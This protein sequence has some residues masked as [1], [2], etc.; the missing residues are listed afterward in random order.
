M[1]SDASDFSG[2]QVFTGLRFTYGAGGALALTYRG[3]S[4][5]IN[6]GLTTTTFSSATVYTVEI[7]GNNKTS[8]TINY[9][10]GANARSVAVQKFDLYINGALIGDDLA[11]ALLPAGTNITSNTFIGVSSTANAANVFVDDVSVYN[12]VPSALGPVIT[13]GGPLTRQQGTAASNATIATVSDTS[14]G[15]LT[16]TATT[17]PVGIT[18][19]TIVNSSGTVT[20]DVAADCTAATG[21]NTVVL[22]LT[23]GTTGLT[24]TANLTVNVDPNTPPVLTYNSANVT[25][26]TTGT[27][28][29]ATGPS[30]NGSVASIVLQ[31]VTP[32][33]T[34]GTLTVNNTTGVVTVPNNIP[35][36]TYTVT[37]RATDNC[38]GA[39]GTTDATFTLT[40]QA[41]APILG[42]Y[43]ATTLGL[44]AST[45]VTPSAAPQNTTSLSVATNTDFKGTFAADP[46]TG[47]VRVTNAHPAGTYTVTVTAFNGSV[48]AQQT[49][50]LMV[51]NGTACTASIRFTNAA[52]VSVGSGPKAMSI[53]DFNGDGNQDLAVANGD[54]ST[55]SI[56][57]GD[58]T[59]SFSGTSNVS[60]GANPT[61]VAIGDFNRDGNQDFAAACN[62]AGAVSIRLGNGSGGFS[63][64]T[65]VSVGANT[66]SVAIGD[67]NGD[68]KQDF[69][70]S[71]AGSNTVSIRLGDGLG[72]FSGTTNVSVG[73]NPSSVAIGDFNEDGKQDFAVA[74]DGPDTVAIR[75]GDGLGGFSGTTSLSVGLNPNAV[76]IGDFNGDGHQDLAVAN[77]SS[78]SVS[79]RLGDGTGGFSGSAL[80]DF[81]A[82]G[83]ESVA[84]GDFN[85]DGK[86][87]FATSGRGFGVVTIRLG[88]GLGGFG[89]R[90]FFNV[91][92]SSIFVAIGDFNGDG[93]QDF[94][95]T[96]QDSSNL[97][98]RLG[99][100]DLPPSITPVASMLTAGQTVSATQ[101]ATAADAVDAANTL[102]LAISSDGTTFGNSATL[103]GVTVT[104]TDSNAGATGTNP[105]ALGN[106]LANVAAACA[107]TNATF[108]LRVTD[109]SGN[110]DT[111]D[112]SVTVNA[113]NLGITLGASPTVLQGTTSANLPYT[114]TTGSPNQ[115]SIDYDTT[116]NTAGFVDVSNATLTAS[117][118]VLVIPGAAAAATYNA[119]LTVRDSATGCISS[120]VSF[121]VTV[122]ACPTTFTVEDTIDSPDDN[123][124]DGV[125]GDTDSICT[126]RAAIMEANALAA[127][128]CGSLTIN[129]SVTGTINVGTELPWVEHPNL[130]IQGPGA[131]LL[132]VTRNAAAAFTIFI[133]TGDVVT[134]ND[135]TIS[136]GDAG[137]LFPVGGGLYNGG[138][139][140]TINRCHITGNTANRGG[141]VF[142]EAGDT[143]INDSTI[144]NNSAASEGGGVYNFASEGDSSITLTNCTISGNSVTGSGGPATA[145]GV[146]IYAED[147][148]NATVNLVNCT[149]TNNTAASSANAGGIFSGVEDGDS[150]ANINLINTIL[151]GNG[152][153][154]ALTANGGLITS[155]GNNLDGDGT[156]GFTNGVNGDI[157]GTVGT[158]INPLL[159]VLG[160][161]GG[162][163][164]THALLP[165]SPAIN[166]GTSTGAPAADQRGIARPQLT[167][168][169]I[170]AFESQGFTLA[171]A[172][173]NNQSAVVNS[174][175]SLPLS[176]T[177][178]ANDA[179]VPVDGGIV[180]FTPPG[181]GASATIASNPATIGGGTATSGTVTA[182]SVTG[183]YS[184][185]ANASGATAP[186][187]FSL[188]NTCQTITVNA[189]GINT[190]TVGVAFSQMF[191]QTGGIG[192][193]TFSTAS[194]LP[195]GITLAADGTLAGTPTQGGAFPLVVVATDSNGCTGSVNYTLTINA[196]P[197]INAVA[198]TRIEGS[199]SSSSTIAN[200]SDT[201]T[202][203]GSLTV[204]VNSAASATV[205]GVT[206]SNLI[207]TGGTISADV[208]AACGATTANFTL[209]VT[210]GGGATNTAMLTVTVDANTPPVLTYSNASVLTG[211]SQNISP[212]T[213]PSDNGSVTTIAVQDM[214][215]YTGGIS[216]NNLTGVISISAAAPSG[217]HT[218]TIRA[219]DQCGAFTDA[220]FTLTVGCVNTLTVNNLGEGAD[221]APGDGV[222]ETANGNGICTLRAA[223]QEANALPGCSP[224]TINFSVTGTITL[225][226]GQLLVTHPNLTVNGPGASQL[227]VSGNNAS[228]IFEI[229]IAATA[230][231]S[232]VTIT[233][234]NGIGATNSGDGG[235]IYSKGK[236]TLTGCV[237]TGNTTTGVTIHEGG[238]INN[239]GTQLLTLT[240]CTISNNTANF[241]GAGVISVG[242]LVMTGC[243]VA[244]NT[245][246]Y[247]S[248]SGRG[249]GIETYATTT[250]T[251]ST[252]SNN[253]ID[254][255]TGDNAGGIWNCCG[256]L[257]IIN[258]TITGNSAAG[259]SGAPSAGGL[260]QDSCCGGSVT[261]LN[262]II[263]GNTGTSG[264]VADA[265][266]TFISNGYNL[267]GDGT[268]STGFTGTGDQVGTTATP[269][270]AFLSVL[271]NF[272][273]LTQTHALL[274]G[275]PAINA[276]TSTG[277][278]TTD[279]RGI[280]RF[281][282]TDIGAFES[283]GFVLA[284]SGGS[285]QTALLNASFANPL[286][287]TVTANSASE[288]VNGGQVTFTPP[289]SGASAV[290]VTTPATIASGAASVTATANGTAGSY[291][292]AATANGA[293]PTVNFALTNNVAPTVTQLVRGNSSPTNASSL[294][295]NVGFSES[296]TNATA[297]NFTLVPGGSVTGAAITNVV[298]NMGAQSCVVTVNTG[299]GSGTLGLNMTN[300]TGVTDSGGA[301]LSNLPVTGEVYTI[302]KDAPDTT[303][304]S[305]PVNPTNSTSATFTFTGNDGS[306]VGVAGF[307][308][309]LDG[310]SFAACTSPQS[311]TGL[312][313]GQHT[314]QVR[315]IDTLG[316]AD[317]TPATYM[318]TVDTTAPT[319]TINQAAG[320]ADPTS[321]SPINFTVVFSEAVTGFANADVSLSG[322]AGATTS[323]VTEIAPNNGTTYNVAV[324]GMSTPGTVSASILANAAQDAVANTSAASSSTDNTVTYN[325]LV[326][327]TTLTVNDLGDT[328]DANPGDGLCKDATNKC[329]LRA[330]IEEANAV[331]A[332]TPLTIN[333]SVTGTINLGTVLPALDHPNLTI[334][335]PGATS[336]DVHRNSSTPFRIFA[337]SAS[338]TVTITGLK[339][340]NGLAAGTINGGGVHNSGTLTLSQCV[341]SGNG[342][343]T[344]SV[345]G[346]GFGGGIYSSGPLTIDQ[347]EISGNSGRSG[348]G[349]THN[350]LGSGFPLI[351][352]NS[353]ISGNTGVQSGGFDIRNT[354][355][356]LTNCTISGNSAPG[357]IGGIDQ[358]A[359]SGNT[360]SVLLTNCTVTN[361]TGSAA[362]ETFGFAGV[363]SLTTTLKNTLVA[364]NIGANFTTTMGTVTS[365]GNNLDSD[366]TSGFTNG[367]NGDI[368]GASGSLIN[369]LLG[370]LTQNGGSTNTH[371]LLPGSPAID[372]GGAGVS[373]DQ[374]GQA[375]PFDI[376]GVA[377]AASGNGSDIGAVEVQCSAITLAGLPGGLLGVPYTASNI[378]GGG[379]AP[380]SLSLTGGS[381]PPG[382]T[383]SGNSLSGT[384]T[385][386]GT[387]SFT[388]A[389][390]D[391]Y[392]CMG[393]QSYTVG[394]TCP[395]IILSPTAL[396]NATV[397]TAYPQTISASPALAYTFSVTNGALP[398]GLTLNPN[399]SFSG[400]PTQTG[401]FN[402]RV[403]ASFG[404]CSTFADYILLV[405][406]PT[407]TVNPSSLPG[408]TLGTAYNQTVS[409]S[410]AGTYFYS[411]TSGALP[412]GLTLNGATGAITGTPINP[413]L[414]TFTV[415]AAAGGCRGSRTYTVEIT[416][417]GV[418]ITP[419]SLPAATAGSFYT[420]TIN[421]TPAGSYT[422][423][424]AQGNLPSGLTLNPTTG[425]ISG[426]PAVVGTVSFIVKV[427]V[428]N[429]CS[430]TQAYTLTTNCPPAVTLAPA[431]LPN[432][433]MGTAYSQVLSA[434]P[435]G[436]S[437]MFTVASGSLPA[438]LTLNSAT[439]VLSGTP[440]ANGSFTFTVTAT[441]FGSC[442]GSRQYT[443]VI[444]NGGCPAITLP[445]SLPAGSTGQ[446]YN[447]PVAASPSGSYSYTFT[448]NLPPGVTLYSS[449]GVLLGY[450]TANGTYNFT[451]TATGANNC[452][453]SQS[454]SVVIGAGSLAAINDFSGDRR[455]DFVLWRAA[456]RQWLIVDGATNSAQTVQ[457]GQA[458]PCRDRRLRR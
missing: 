294:T 183:T 437:Y 213:G 173:G 180:T 326:C 291:N 216:V 290:L 354:S 289:G 43:S 434:S 416:C 365:L 249:G 168:F 69:A 271:G 211:G 143:Y 262:S 55:V 190:G 277:A 321:S 38:G 24:N 72:G 165:G 194:T 16:V 425:V 128:A 68:G 257:T 362:I 383:I 419:A 247:T 147:G 373:T 307:E 352:T 27:V 188:T 350:G 228:R 142:N 59:G 242:N 47:V 385:Q 65:N 448:G 409:A 302:D 2:A 227:T 299:T 339:I 37:I 450:P 252:I 246:T 347:C 267:I 19:G 158:P 144:S 367:A 433:A 325:N 453:A 167:L 226:N 442:A 174:A 162:T 324:S 238:G 278:P 452:S 341:I 61:S 116:A 155:Q 243:T 54:V 338:R 392:G 6:T 388:L 301:G 415:S 315:A 380:Y 133:V 172:S 386:I 251:N 118:I 151:A 96:N 205:N 432:G 265:G 413:G 131:N 241:G 378:A 81:I 160:N 63:G 127:T 348:A 78:G 411:V 376:P 400:T 394:V 206:V 272:G 390:Q 30:D 200:V 51:Q 426:L 369:A 457:W 406:C 208:V 316:N 306:G 31:S 360:S 456:Q 124:G 33:T 148:G 82:A 328:P 259:N 154:Q 370:P 198:V 458:G 86:Q 89:N 189:P 107:A 41:P 187:N 333:F 288:P 304:T 105:D 285:P 399:G 311:Y 423:S 130:T 3:G 340:T 255:G 222:C 261:V 161:Y 279:Q 357:R 374:R 221:F 342:I 391:A 443:V 273:G 309:K 449:L 156:T 407:I 184:V 308:C 349:I 99:G 410:P 18:V 122:L 45:T 295:F 245:N 77:S 240:N 361:N 94:A 34:P 70:A 8:G 71:N 164:P 337:I 182:N 175:F 170:G 287:V 48:S 123:P 314:F 297:S 429:S 44:A 229:N 104:L 371:L 384:P 396:P 210:D 428:P 35:A 438:G 214:G 52:D 298:C 451:V 125:C 137:V 239:A 436:G 351:I 157:V 136:N 280:S 177:V 32:A 323:A 327:P 368:V 5:F 331:T 303:I 296:V 53:G 91:V 232:G 235:G 101:I 88:D 42:T 332:C 26:G 318:W 13:A 336:L 196:L 7:V 186:V 203:A 417:Q 387:F 300:S 193:T 212:A 269:I 110:T 126:L 427:S 60:V 100:C 58:G 95:T 191:T 57:L 201:E 260:L 329:T 330:A 73:A 93:R 263:A 92:T 17:V 195:N 50:A 270:N 166:A 36:G 62:G 215:T 40:V 441:G 231:I 178:T 401:T 108:K 113:H 106:V 292:V 223:I 135:L 1:Y 293:T 403:T 335:G 97:S 217:T 430:T 234:G 364:G 319:V 421:V 334:N 225:T 29:P 422:F 431:S 22:T 445:A 256:P 49:F 366:G 276:G 114:A 344:T 85:G 140:L 163:T 23:N 372:K 176:V 381:L 185:S 440:T 199:P 11:E 28:N 397:N 66:T 220:T 412:N 418:S 313:D 84:I 4:S 134:I 275:S 382:V 310:G 398:A 237:V 138:G 408:G 152:N 447:T 64:T 233:N 281:G 266:G 181:S 159:A 236:L 109:S 171:I 132:T 75:L 345:G 355:A 20:A 253:H 46:T 111:K 254:N 424:L 120:S 39:N 414:F 112:F 389:A 169:D 139:V 153:A 197:T 207:N 149:I 74:N 420:Q 179:G 102:R 98:I 117:P 379:T 12:M 455:S 9:T 146:A 286:A 322:T 79:I 375:R 305:N 312:A 258:S 454:Y 80:N 320:Q 393:S 83:T 284:L 250:I 103:N 274:P 87:D 145:G 402:F 317:Q 444:G 404:G 343:E 76:V 218:I 141:G 282:A 244:N 150:E 90:L 121:T 268:G 21:A 405:N 204:T 115:Y 435:A 439:G 14:T 446:F 346:S 230:S 209:T 358:V 10:Y 129:F 248:D 56:R 25:S 359:Q 192:A 283:Q 219:T 15:T 377:N 264:A 224:F 395:A 353:T 202:A 119:T 356:S 363:T 67:F